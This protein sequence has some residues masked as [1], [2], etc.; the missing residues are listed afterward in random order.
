MAEANVPKTES[1]PAT[2]Q[3]WGPISILRGP[4]DPE[5]PRRS[6]REVLFS[7]ERIA[8]ADGKID[9]DSEYVRRARAWWEHPYNP[10][11]WYM[12]LI[13]DT[14]TSGQMQPAHTVD[15]ATGK[16]VR[17]TATGRKVIREYDPEKY[18]VEEEQ[19]PYRQML[20]E[21][22]PETRDRRDWCLNA[23]GNCE[24]QIERHFQCLEVLA[25][26]PNPPFSRNRVELLRANFKSSAYD[27]PTDERLNRVLV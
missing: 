1:P 10:V 3:W 20:A 18:I 16:D 25:E 12:N 22:C 23:F 7:A 21:I 14:L 6:M 19:K 13:A 9:P 8:D 11:G 2:T 24:S 27:Y 15:I 26:G 17:E 4:R 5:K